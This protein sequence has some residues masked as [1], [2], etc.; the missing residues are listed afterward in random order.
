M[1]MFYVKLV[2][3]LFPVTSPKTLMLLSVIQVTPLGQ[4]WEGTQAVKKYALFYG[5]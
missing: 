2:A 4:S 3:A 5:T 1:S